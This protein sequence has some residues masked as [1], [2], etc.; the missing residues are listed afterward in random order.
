[1]QRRTAA[2]STTWDGGGGGGEGLR[3]GVGGGANTR[4]WSALVLH[5]LGVPEV[6]D[7]EQRLAR[8]VDERVLELDVAIDDALAVAIVESNDELL[9]EPACLVLVQAA[10]LADVFERVAAVGILHGDAEVVLG[11]KDLHTAMGV[12]N[13]PQG[14]LSLLLR[15]VAH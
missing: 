13:V 1:M 7:L 3:G 5:V 2:I 15:T 6:A 4:C 11:Q 14:P 12:L 9:E 10:L 8:P